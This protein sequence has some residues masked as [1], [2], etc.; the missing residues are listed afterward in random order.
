LVGAARDEIQF[1]QQD[2]PRL[3]I[4]IVPTWSHGFEPGF[5]GEDPTAGS[6]ELVVDWWDRVRAGG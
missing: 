4:H 3:E 5:P 1:W 2:P 6:A